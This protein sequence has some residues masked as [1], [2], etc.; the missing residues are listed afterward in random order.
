MELKELV[1]GFGAALKIEGLSL[2]AEGKAAFTADGMWVGIAD[3]AVTRTFSLT[4]RI[5]ETPPEGRERLDRLFLKTNAMFVPGSGMSV[6]L[7]A[8]DRYVLM[9]SLEYTYLTTETFAEKV[10]AFLNELERLCA[11]AKSFPG[12]TQE[13]AKAAADSAAEAKMLSEGRFLQV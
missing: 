12:S 10:E 13:V 3:N 2:D 5:G 11:L 4:G 8:E 1:D 9:S 7:D 6:G